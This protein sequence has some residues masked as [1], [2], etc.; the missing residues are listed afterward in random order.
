MAGDPK[1]LRGKLNDV[2]QHLR[3][4]TIGVV[5][6]DKQ[7]LAI[8]KDF[9][10]VY[11]MKINPRLIGFDPLNRGGLGVQV[12]SVF[13]LGADI[14]MIGFDPE[15]TRAALVVEVGP[16][17]TSLRELRQYNAQLLQGTSM[18]EVPCDQILYT[19]LASSHLTGFLRALQAESPWPSSDIPAG[20]GH[21]GQLSMDILRAKDPAFYEAAQSGIT[22]T[23]LKASVREHPEVLNLL[24][25]ARN[26]PGHVQR[27]TSQIQG[28]LTIYK[29]WSSTKSD[30]DM[31]VIKRAVLRDCPVWGQGAGSMIK[32]VAEKASADGKFLFNF[33]DF[34]KKYV[35]GKRYIRDNLFDVLADL[36]TYLAY[37]LA[38]AAF[39]CPDSFVVNQQCTLIL[40]EHCR[41]LAD[42][43]IRQGEVLLRRVRTVL[44]QSGIEAKEQPGSPL[45]GVFGRFD[46]TVA[47]FLTQKQQTSKDK[48]GSLY[49]CAV[50][51]VQDLK[52]A[53]P[54]TKEAFLM[55]E[56]AAASGSASALPSSVAS[57]L[58]DGADNHM[59]LKDLDSEGMSSSALSRLREKGFTCGDTVGP[60]GGF[61]L[62]VIQKIDPSGDGF[63][64]QLAQHPI[65]SKAGY[66]DKPQPSGKSA[67]KGRG[68]KTSVDTTSVTLEI[69]ASAWEKRDEKTTPRAVPEWQEHRVDLGPT[70][71]DILRSYALLAVASA[72]HSIET[73]VQGGEPHLHLQLLDAPKKKVITGKFFEKGTLVLLPETSSFGICTDGDSPRFPITVQ[74][75]GKKE[76]RILACKPPSGPSGVAP[77]WYVSQTADKGAI[78]MVSTSILVGV[79]KH[80]EWKRDPMPKFGKKPQATD[81][82]SAI[83][84]EVPLLI[85]SVDL[86]S[87]TELFVAKVEETVNKRRGGE[88]TGASAPKKRA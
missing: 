25:E 37:A 85:N 67:G 14:S 65:M 8:L 45:I 21:D 18:S 36:P 4:G 29:L 79:V 77:L 59:E 3:D 73:G 26:A 70:S 17:A 56:L 75:F 60:R 42:E 69:L 61:G 71:D 43:Q 39:T 55:N 46:I 86:P 16:A 34:M 53:Y 58:L 5:T 41:N 76:T 13:D 84:A 62:F 78:N 28:L 9:D 64:V 49:D 44:P 57:A 51:L 23:V 68:K 33:A 80:A 38:K 48:M 40:R 87:G 31:G 2:L 54:T 30:A 63:L 24:Q 20:L 19:A 7:L 82:A 83:Y 72:K 66:S 88:S 27:A 47:L 32:F 35:G 10:L 22:Y 52:K 50:R 81:K 11:E 74:C 15:L 1:S 6:A 12:P